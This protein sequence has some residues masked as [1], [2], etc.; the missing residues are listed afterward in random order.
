M[1]EEQ[2]NDLKRIYGKNITINKISKTISDVKEIE[3]DIKENDVIAVVAPLR[4][5]QQICKIAGNK[6]VIIAESE[7]KVLNNE[8][9]FKFK[10]WYQIKKIDVILEKL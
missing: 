3:K 7:R 2:L 9:Q 6:P 10:G 4:L 8:V 5:L 1:S